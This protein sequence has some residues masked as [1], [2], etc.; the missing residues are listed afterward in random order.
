MSRMNGGNLVTGALGATG[1]FYLTDRIMANSN[2]KTL[3]KVLPIG[4]AVLGYGLFKG[5]R[6]K[7]RRRKS[8]RKSR[9]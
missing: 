5:G 9:R 4:A 3:K 2:N 8:K 1:A 7:S 6:R